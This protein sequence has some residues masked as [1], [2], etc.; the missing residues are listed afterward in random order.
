MWHDT[1]SKEAITSTGIDGLAKEPVAFEMRDGEAFIG[2]V[3]V[4]MFWGQLHVKYLTVDEA[5][6]NQG[7]ARSLMEHAFEF[8][9]RQGCTFA[10]VETMNFQAPG[11]YQ[12]LGFKA[13]MIRE[14]YALGTSFYYL[15]KEL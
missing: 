4:Q 12:K 8:G 5:Y 13:E 15:R 1:F 9:K 11:F 7:H 6:R 3:V 14:G 2:C 10:F